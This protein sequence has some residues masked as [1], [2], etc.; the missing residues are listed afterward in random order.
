MEKDKVNN[1]KKEKTVL[2]DSGEL[3][4]RTLFE[5]HVTVEEENEEEEEKEL[6][7]NESVEKDD[8]EELNWTRGKTRVVEEN[9]KNKYHWKFVQE[10][11]EYIERK[12]STNSDDTTTSMDVSDSGV[13]LF[14]SSF[15]IDSGI[16]ANVPDPDS[17]TEVLKELQ[18]SEDEDEE[19]EGCLDIPTEENFL[20]SSTSVSGDDDAAETNF[21]GRPRSVHFEDEHWE[22]GEYRIKNTQDN[23]YSSW[24]ETRQSCQT[25][26]RTNTNDFD[27]VS[28]GDQTFRK[29]ELQSLTKSGSDFELIQR[30]QAAGRPHNVKSANRESVRELLRRKREEVEDVLANDGRRR[31]PSNERPAGNEE[32]IPG[33]RRRA[34][35]NERNGGEARSA[36]KRRLSSKERTGRSAEREY[37]DK[38]AES[39]ERNVGVREGFAEKRV[40]L[41]ERAYSVEGKPLERKE[42]RTLSSERTSVVEG[43]SIDKF[44]KT[45]SRERT[46]RDSIRKLDRK[47]DS[48]S[49]ET[50]VDGKNSNSIRN[51]EKYNTGKRFDEQRTRIS[52]GHSKNTNN[53]V[54]PEE[55]SRSRSPKRENGRRV[56]VTALPIPVEECETGVVISRRDYAMFKSLVAS[57]SERVSKEF[58]KTNGV[59]KRLRSPKLSSQRR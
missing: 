1:R 15:T 36:E 6:N 18:Y 57:G 39:K 21:F 22:D 33:E 54:Y 5:L 55:K 49:V 31:L 52:N 14:N 16:C 19:P 12:V 9:L 20:K 34:S 25:E 43:R 56:G 27:L 44:R 2:N 28:H 24:N 3:F 11:N 41:K 8:D 35:S 50:C 48:R 26:K 7:E 59:T 53:S 40:M 32:G 42:R 17:D 58:V 4:D 38:R 46:R 29:S 10:N 23:E 13:D 30:H 37:A 47:G 51:T 45:H